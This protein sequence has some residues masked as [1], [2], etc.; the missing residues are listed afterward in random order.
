M[1]VR[2]WSLATTFRSSCLLVVG[3]VLVDLLE[4]LVAGLAV[5]E[6]GP[7]AGLDGGAALADGGREAEHVEVDVHAVGHRLRGS[8]TP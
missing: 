3:E 5:A 6:G 8:R 1:T 4:A 7:V 2:I